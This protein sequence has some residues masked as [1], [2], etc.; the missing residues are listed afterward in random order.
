MVQEEA[1]SKVSSGFEISGEE[2]QIGG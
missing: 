1:S 2:Y